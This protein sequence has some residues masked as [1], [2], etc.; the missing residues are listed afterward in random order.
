ML[1]KL[2]SAP[3][4]AHPA[5]ASLARWPVLAVA[6]VVGLVLLLT[7]GRV[8]Y[9]DDELYFLVAGRHV[10][11]GY[12][13]QGPLVPL[14]ARAMDT[15]FPGSLVGERLPTTVLTAVGV[16]VAALIAR[17]LGGRHRA[18]V[19]TAGLYAMGT[20]PSGHQLT[21]AAVDV[22]VWTVTTW[23]LVRWV[24]LRDDR[25]LL[26]SA[27]WALPEVCCAA[28]SARMISRGRRS[29]AATAFTLRGCLSL[30]GTPGAKL[31]RYETQRR[32]W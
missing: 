2:A 24:R 27:H 10:D 7:S 14:L 3:T 13:D 23:L 4:G 26:D 9:F 32:C 21:T 28:C 18:Q 15:A 8:G 20:L 31:S 25:L 22:F 5:I 11:W 29:A 6:A 17:E 30:S 19:L 1:A 16:V 12:A